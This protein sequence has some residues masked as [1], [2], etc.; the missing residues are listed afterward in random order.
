MIL[1]GNSTADLNKVTIPGRV[2]C[3]AEDVSILSISN[4]SDVNTPFAESGS[5]AHI[6]IQNS[7]I[8]QWQNYGYNTAPEARVY[9]SNI[10][11][12]TIGS[13]SIICEISDIYPGL[14]TYWSFIENCSVALSGGLGGAAPNVTLNNTQVSQWSLA[15]YGNSIVTIIDSILHSLL[16]NDHPMIG[17]SV[18]LINSTISSMSVYGQAR[19]QIFWYLNVHIV[20]DINQD[21]PS[22]N[23]TV[24]FQKGTLV[25]SKFTGEDG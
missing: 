18:V 15:F 7:T 13:S 19:I 2:S 10:E 3:R 20:D 21:V 17:E 9:D 4:S 8:Y 12:L 5:S 25:E 6:V 14:V 23:V 16:A 11:Y 24:T 1:K 22:A